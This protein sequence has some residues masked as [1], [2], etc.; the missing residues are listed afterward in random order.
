M[1]LIIPCP[2]E[3][4]VFLPIPCQVQ[5]ISFILM[6]HLPWVIIMVCVQE[7]VPSGIGMKLPVVVK[8]WMLKGNI[9]TGTKGKGIWINWRGGAGGGT[10]G[11]FGSFWAPASEIIDLCKG[12]TYQ[13]LPI[14]IYSGFYVDLQDD[15]DINLKLKQAPCLFT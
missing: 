8:D 15:G 13:N 14:I 1:V 12:M 10:A 4:P 3:D 6:Y 5:M 11:T 7:I 9:G 2:S